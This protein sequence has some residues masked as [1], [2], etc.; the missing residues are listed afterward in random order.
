MIEYREKSKTYNK[1][2]SEYLIQKEKLENEKKMLDENLSNFKWLE[3]EY[4]KQLLGRLKPVKQALIEYAN[5]KRGET[6]RF[7]FSYLN[8]VFE[9]EIIIDKVIEVFIYKDKT[10]FNNYKGFHYNN[11]YESPKTPNAYCPDFIFTHRETKLT[12]DIE[13]D[14]PYNR[15]R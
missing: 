2:Y 8:R 11:L 14:E 10:D 4:K 15:S 7:F 6:E 13:I 12:I 3:T 5:P 9:D 1:L